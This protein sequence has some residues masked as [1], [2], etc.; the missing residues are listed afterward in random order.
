MG[1]RLGYSN[2]LRAMDNKGAVD[3]AVD[4]DLLRSFELV[5]LRRSE[6][7][8]MYSFLDFMEKKRKDDLKKQKK[9]DLKKQKKH[10]FCT[11]REKIGQCLT[12]EPYGSKERPRTSYEA[13]LRHKYGGYRPKDGKPREFY[14]L[15]KQGNRKAVIQFRKKYHLDDGAIEEHLP[16]TKA[17]V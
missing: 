6:A 14:I 17:R 10:E 16:L 7:K 1:R 12:Y 9:D 13:I 5:P 3:R 2:I 11:L 4:W 8:S 15:V